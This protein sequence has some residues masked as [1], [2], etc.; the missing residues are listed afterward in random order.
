MVQQ[1][2][3]CSRRASRC[4]ERLVDEVCTAVVAR[5]GGDFTPAVAAL[6]RG[7]RP[8][9][10]CAAVVLHLNLA[11]SPEQLYAET[12]AELAD[13]W[14]EAAMMPGAARLLRWLA[15]KRVPVALCTSTPRDVLELKRA[16]LGDLYL[17][18]GDA[19]VAGDDV[20]AGKPAPDAFLAASARLGVP[21]HECLAIEDALTGV[22]SARAAGCAVLAVPSLADRASYCGE[23]TTV[24]ASL[25]DVDLARF[26]LPPLRDW[27]GRAL[28]LEP[29]M[30]LSGPVVRGFGR[31]SKTLGIPTANLCTDALGPAI[32]HAAC[33]GI[34]ICWASVGDAAAD[35]TPPPVHKGVMSIGLNPFFKDREKKK[36]CEPWILHDFGRDFYGE[37]L[38][39]VVAGY[40]RPE[41]DFVSLEALIAQINDD[42]D[43]ARAALDLEPFASLR[44][45]SFLRP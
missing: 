30:R 13:R 42:A 23:R 29:M 41:A 15:A 45:D 25:L 18:F 10:A 26:G 11:V 5:H 7:R 24:L 9:E 43:V 21:P 44:F 33:S 27:V 32:A 22:Q 39:L 38:R 1:R 40:I 35:G 3:Q 36:T 12:S 31:G 37:P 8:L 20:K 28:P 14:G 34:Y 6:G 2:K 17:L 16:G 19:V 4:A